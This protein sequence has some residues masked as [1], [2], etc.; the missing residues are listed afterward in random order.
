MGDD[1]RLRLL[2]APAADTDSNSAAVAVLQRLDETEVLI[3]VDAAVSPAAR[4][5]VAAFVTIIARLVPTLTIESDGELPPNW[6]QADSWDDLLERLS[7]VRP[8]APNPPTR[9]VTV[10]FGTST[11][12][13]DLYV[14]GGDWNSVISNSPASLESA[15]SHALGVHAAACLAVSQVLIKVLGD[16]GFPGVPV[17]ERIETNLIDHGL[18]TVDPGQTPTSLAAPST[19][20]DVAFLGVGSVGTSALALLAT[21]CSPHLHHP[22][23]TLPEV[24]IT[25]VDKDVFDPNRN[26]YRYPA[27]L[28]GE[29][30]AKATGMTARLQS[31]GLTATAVDQDVAS[32]NMTK[33]S[34][35]WNGVLVSSV[36]TITGRLDVADVLGE[37][38]LSAGVAGTALHVQ[39]EKF[40][41]GYA[42]PFCDFVRADPPLTQAG[43]YAQVT[44]IAVSR[45]LALLQEGAVLDA[46]DVAVAVTAGKVP[47]HRSDSLV[48]APLS[49]LVRQAYAEAEVRPQGTEQGTEVVA[50]ASPQVSWFA[51]VLITAELV[52]A[53]LGL[54]T[55]R[56]RVDLDVGGLPAGA[57]RVVPADSTGTC[58]CQSGVR[59]RWHTAL[60]ARDSP[61]DPG[62]APGAAESVK[63]LTA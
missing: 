44:G 16:L 7:A 11:P 39:W 60:Y 15:T 58:V 33:D 36:D 45:I 42:C 18:H 29:T 52:K 32:W 47:A 20:L 31:L 12:G 35:G 41:D 22:G 10:G 43:V 21:V 25:T 37:R 2:G 38:T 19:A 56:R 54:P 51:G 55:L 6:W 14:G 63:V 50:V 28:G 1:P 27:L 8:A 3:T 57:V 49:D 34:P 5:A 4:I 62:A 17:Q 59:R 30:D 9:Q 61:A 13:L 24:T 26:P 23:T 40:G 53:I 46:S 48:G